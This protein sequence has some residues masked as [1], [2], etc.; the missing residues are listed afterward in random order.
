VNPIVASLRRWRENY[1]ASRLLSS[2]SKP[3]ERTCDRVARS[4][5]THV[6][7]NGIAFRLSNGQVL[8]IGRDCGIGLATGLYWRGI[9]SFEPETSRTLR[10][11]F[12]RASTFVDIGANYGFYSLLAAHW[13]PHIRVVAFEPVSQIFAG[14]RRNIELNGLQ[15]RIHAYCVALSDQSG[16]AKLFFPSSESRDYES[17][18]T[19]AQGNWQQRKGAPVIEIQASSFADFERQHPVRLDVVKIDVEDHEASVLRGMEEAIRRDR[20]FIV[21]EILPRP[22]RN[23]KTREIIDSLGYTAYWITPS[24]FVRVTRF[25]FDRL[26]SEN[27]LLSPV[28]GEGEVLTDLEILWSK[29]Q[30]ALAA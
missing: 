29:R 23:E 22:H 14:L 7:R 19:L 17:T 13:N 25:D 10:F 20:P 24:G 21:C 9:D 2:L 16:A 26:E 15:G 28:G 27:F 8:R 12:S 11:F 18:A 30:A 1:Y 5:R 4:L 3:V 6:P